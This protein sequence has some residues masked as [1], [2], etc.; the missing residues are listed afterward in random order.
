M[1]GVGQ[2]CARNHQE[3]EQIRWLLQLL[4]QQQSSEVSALVY[5]MMGLHLLPA[6]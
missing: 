1:D 5:T 6:H 3:G 2:R 4:G